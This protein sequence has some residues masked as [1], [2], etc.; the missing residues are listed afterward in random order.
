[1]IPMAERFTTS[2]MQC[3]LGLLSA[4][5]IIM[6]TWQS[7][8]AAPL[9]RSDRIVT[10]MPGETLSQVVE[11]ELGSSAYWPA[12]AEHNGILDPADLKA[13]QK[14]RI[15]VPYTRSKERAV[16]LFVKGRVTHKPALSRTAVALKKGQQVQVGDWWVDA[17]LLLCVL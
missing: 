11:R 5:L 17:K 15:P 7:A 12:V 14:L 8:V 6:L 3:C 16:V 1:M 2:M 13:G 9:L 4:C 10:I